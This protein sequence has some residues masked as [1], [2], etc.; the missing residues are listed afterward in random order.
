MS[1]LNLDIINRSVSSH[2]QSADTI[3]ATKECKF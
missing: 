2:R 3:E 1:P